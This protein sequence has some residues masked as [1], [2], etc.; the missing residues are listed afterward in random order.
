MGQAVQRAGRGVAGAQPHG[1]H[2]T[3]GVGLGSH[4]RLTVVDEAV[5]LGAH[6]DRTDTAADAGDH[7]RQGR[8][9]PQ[10]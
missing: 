3:H 9:Q 4:H 1:K 5:D 7:Q 10:Q 6:A 8:V 2:L